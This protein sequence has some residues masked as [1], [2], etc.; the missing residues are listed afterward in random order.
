MENR[1]R[2]KHRFLIITAIVIGCLVLALFVLW[3]NADYLLTGYADRKLREALSRSDSFDLNYSS[4]NLN[5]AKGTVRL[6]GISF[7]KDSIRASIKRIE[8]GKIDLRK[9]LETRQL[10]LDYIEVAGVELRFVQIPKAD[11]VSSDTA[12]VTTQSPGMKK[13]LDTIGVKKL[14]LD[15]KQVT[16]R[17]QG[18]HMGADINGIRISLS[19]IGYGVS[20][21]NLTYCDSLYE[22]DVTD[23]ALITAD[24]LHAIALDSLKT[25]NSGVV[26]L[27]D[28]KIRNTVG[29][30]QLSALKGKIPVSWINLHVNHLRT[31][32]VNLIRS[33]L[34]HKFEIDSIFVSGKRL[35]VFRD[36]RYPSKTVIKMPQEGLTSIKMPLHI[37]YLEMKMPS[38]KMEILRDKGGTGSLNLHDVSLLAHNISSSPGSTMDVRTRVHLGRG[39]GDVHMR[40]DND[41]KS[42]FNVNA[43]I[44]NVKGTEFNTLLQPVLGVSMEADIK[45]LNSSIKANGESASGTFCM[46]YDNLKTS[47]ED[48]SYLNQKL[49]DKE[50]IINKVAGLAIHSSNPRKANEEP[51]RCQLSARRDP[52]KNFGSYMVSILLDGVKKTVLR[53][54]P[55]KEVEKLKSSGEAIKQK[56][57]KVSEKVRGT[58][59]NI[60]EKKE[61]VV[62]KAKNTKEHIKEKKGQI[63]DKKQELKDKI[64]KKNR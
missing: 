49:E 45:S 18:S 29:K 6:N 57:E 22:L 55:L 59:E 34:E 21:G 20:S 4:L 64:F 41:K 52:Y 53:D 3:K 17:R 33:A 50:K 8:A 56:K 35:S 42:S 19:D 28:L 27:S 48:A 5:L 30:K 39:R 9:V 47:V 25:R 15:G 38:L 61:T 14:I 58:K 54:F 12:K 44:Y 24:G 32:A 1:P 62:E 7:S 2:H 63:K 46:Q 11:T 36:A 40:L 16:F 60:K 23:L 10:L 51:F 43:N 13:F 31:S 26:E 37:G